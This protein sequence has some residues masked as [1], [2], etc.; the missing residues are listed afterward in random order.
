MADTGKAL[1]DRLDHLYWLLHKQ[2]RRRHTQANPV[3]DPSKGQGRILAMLKLEDAIST[4]DLAFLLDV[5]VSTLNEMLSKLEK[6]GYVVREADP[7][8]RRVMLVRLTD[9]GR[10]AQQGD[11]AAHTDILSC[12]S[13]QEQGELCGYLDRLIGAFEAEL[14]PG[15]EEY[16]ERVKAMHNRVGDKMMDRFERHL[17]WHRKTGIPS[18][19]GTGGTRHYDRSANK[20]GEKN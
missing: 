6:G 15:N 1:M 2:Q 5:R 7:Q 17:D 8:D 12:L 20:D 16:Y 4:K 13:K 9:K 18:W 10:N 11:G 19:P 14:E 3:S